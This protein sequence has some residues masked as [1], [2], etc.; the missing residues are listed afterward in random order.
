M[1]PTTR[2]LTRRWASA[3]ALALAFVSLAAVPPPARAAGEISIT[4]R[5]LMG[6]RFTVGEWA[7]L[8]V[9]LAND[10]APVTGSLV[11]AS[12]AGEVRRA[13]ELPAGSR[14]E[15]V[16]YV[17]PDAFTREVTVRF[18][19]EEETISAVAAVTGLDASAPAVA[20]V[21]DD[22]G[23]LRTQLAERDLFSGITPFDVAPADLPDRPEP[24]SGVDVLVWAGDSTGLREEQRRTIER[25]VA[26]GGQLVV[27]G[28]P[29]WQARTAAFADLLPVTGLAARDDVDLAPLAELAGDMPAGV[30]TATVTTGTLVDGARELVAGEDD[31]PLIAM[32]PQGAGRVIWI[33]A[34]LASAGFSA[35]EAGGA[36]WGR[37]LTTN[38]SPFRG[39]PTGT[40]EA[41]GMTGALARLPALDVP[42]AELLLAVLAGYILL[43]GPI[44]FIVL[45]RVDRRE[46]AWVTAPILVLLFSACSFGIGTA[47]KGSQIIVNQLSVVRSVAGGSAA[48]VTTWAGVFSPSRASYDLSVAGDALLAAVSTRGDGATLPLP[49]EQG[50]PARLRGLAVNVLE[51]QAV[52]ADTLIAHEPP[53]SL[54]WSVAENRI[55]GTVTNVSDEPLSDVAV[56]TSSTG[57]MIG[58][59]AAG[60]SREFEMAT[61]DF[62]GA[63]PSDQVYGFGRG[64]AT[65]DESRTRDVRRRVLAG[66]FGYGDGTPITSF[67]ASAD[68]GPFVVG[69]HSGTPNDVLV[70]GETVQHYRQSIEV[71]SGRPEA[72]SGEIHVHPLDMSIRVA[73]SEGQVDRPDRTSVLIGNGGVATFQVQLPLEVRGLRPSRM[74]VYVAGDSSS[75]LSEQN[76]VGSLPPG[77]VA[78]VQDA[79][80]GS[81]TEL[82]DLALASRFTIADP[83]RMLSPDGTITIRVSG[84]E[85]P[86]EFGAYG[87]YVGA[88]VWGTLP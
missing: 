66:L 12:G 6:G 62:T 75:P 18:A 80:D 57:E 5:G 82:G 28:G 49:T 44:S 24:M 23:A 56:V 1:R 20:L 11:A 87:V 39:E 31:A 19:T 14:K 8:A 73:S 77:Y 34:D 35:W 53:L 17:R 86:A 70:D 61:G 37:L 33:G 40:D 68:R 7:A 88:S 43:I 55:S 38:R 72:V 22:D 48:S 25:W 3:V 79:T 54:V 59:L 64:D 74:N 26:G 69:W 27:L 16:L 65:D 84:T 50:D 58:D 78:E 67:S 30:T 45:R 13:V 71:V 76:S 60:E 36:V 32:R 85:V 46:L 4:A 2:A 42:P 83:E 51:M 63:Q 81:W 41:L 52:R 15:V 9:S 10:G 21:G 47:L 29:D